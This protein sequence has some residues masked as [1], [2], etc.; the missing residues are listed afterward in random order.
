VSEAG[1]RQAAVVRWAQ[2]ALSNVYKRK[3]QVKSLKGKFED[4][5][6]AGCTLPSCRESLGRNL[7]CRFSVVYQET[8][9]V[10]QEIVGAFAPGSEKEIGFTIGDY[11]R[12]R[13]LVIDP[14]VVYSTYLVTTQETVSQWISRAMLM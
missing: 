3:A 14:V 4:R 11:D 10:R 9:G 7:R 1:G 13:P 12:S 8:A 6:R 2:P 5:L